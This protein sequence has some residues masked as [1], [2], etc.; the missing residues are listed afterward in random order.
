MKQKE[1]IFTEK[2][3][4]YFVCFADHPG[5]RDEYRDRF[6]RIILGWGS[7]G[8]LPGLQRG[9]LPVRLHAQDLLV[10]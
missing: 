7:Q 9:H 6:R 5:Y 1:A 10:G 8:C 2:A 4:H 3:K